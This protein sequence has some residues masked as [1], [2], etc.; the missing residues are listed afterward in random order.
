MYVCVCECVYVYVYV[1]VCV[2]VHVCVPAYV[3]AKYYVAKYKGSIFFGYKLCQDYTK[4]YEQ[5]YDM[6]DIYRRTQCVGCRAR[7][8]GRCTS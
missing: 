3:L 8:V 7:W 2:C 6:F 1:Y 4:Q 5:I